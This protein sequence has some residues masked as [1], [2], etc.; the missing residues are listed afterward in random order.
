M[1]ISKSLSEGGPHAELL[2]RLL[3]DRGLFYSR[4][5]MLVCMFKFL[6]VLL[7]SSAGAQDLPT[8]KALAPQPATLETN[9]IV[10]DPLVIIGGVEEA[11]RALQCVGRGT[12]CDPGGIVPRVGG[13]PAIRR[14]DESFTIA[15]LAGAKV[16]R[17]VVKQ[18]RSADG[19]GR[20]A[21]GLTFSR[22][23]DSVVLER[24]GGMERSSGRRDLPGMSSP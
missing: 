21:T 10:K 5:R 22:K 19:R 3:R 11:W 23:F 13:A 14:S 6:M 4:E 24:W 18:Y 20:N 8:D 1:L 16:R 7:L 12:K 2:N 9:Q 15:T 17:I